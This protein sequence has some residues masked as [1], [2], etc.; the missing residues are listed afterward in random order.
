MLRFLRSIK[1]S[2]AVVLVIAATPA[3]AGDYV[4][5][6]DRDTVY[7]ANCQM[8]LN[9]AGTLQGLT[10]GGSLSCGSIQ[11]WYE[12]VATNSPW[13]GAS[14]YWKLTCVSGCDQYI[15]IAEGGACADGNYHA[16]T[17]G[18]VC[19]VEWINWYGAP[20]GWHNVVVRWD[21]ADQNYTVRSSSTY[22]LRFRKD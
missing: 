10:G 22:T 15:N 3:F 6:T 9:K 14:S 17:N 19:T 16:A 7:V 21:V 8:L 1:A 20:T 11:G 4:S 5:M 12:P 2:I 18:A 13:P